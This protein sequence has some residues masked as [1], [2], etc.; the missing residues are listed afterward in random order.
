MIRLEAPVI[1]PRRRLQEVG[2]GQGLLLPLKS[3]PVAL[4]FSEFFL[5]HQSPLLLD[6][7]RMATDRQL[8][9]PCRRSRDSSAKSHLRCSRVSGLSS[10]D[11]GIESAAR[12]N[13]RTL[14]QG[15]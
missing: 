10:D 1:A 14:S 3:S 12:I 4:Q 6:T 8:N 13:T 7:S 11:H 2:N 9:H 5:V 15:E